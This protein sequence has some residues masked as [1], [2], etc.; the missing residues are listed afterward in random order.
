M[1]CYNLVPA[2]EEHE[3]SPHF[4]VTPLYELGITLAVSSRYQGP[5]RVGLAELRT[6]SWL[7]LDPVV[8]THSIISTLFAVH[9]LKTPERIIQCS[10]LSMYI[11]LAG[12]LDVVSVWTDA[13]I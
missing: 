12:R 3:K 13:G 6:M 1:D 7:V 9:K 8:D 10:S 2:T 4:E 11:E 5:M